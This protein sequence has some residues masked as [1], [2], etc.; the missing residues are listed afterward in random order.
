MPWHYQKQAAEQA[1]ARLHGVIGI[2]N[3][4]LVKPVVDVTE[5]SDRIRLA[6]RRSWLLDDAMVT[7]RADGGR[8]HLTGTVRSPHDRQLAWETAWAAP[9]ATSVENDIAIV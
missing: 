7:V 2:S 9:G 1:I 8:V 6:L 5:I 3:H 4:L